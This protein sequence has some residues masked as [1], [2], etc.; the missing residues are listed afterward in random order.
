MPHVRVLPVGKTR[1]ELGEEDPFVSLEETP[2]VLAD[3]RTALPQLRKTLMTRWPL[4]N[5]VEI[6]NRRITRRHNPHD[7]TQVYRD[8][9]FGIAIYISSR[10]VRIFLEEVARGAGK[11]IGP[12]VGRQAVA[13]MRYVQRWVKRMG[14]RVS[15]RNRE[16]T[17]KALPTRKIKKPRRNS[18]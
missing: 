15:S 13:A 14:G 3:V 9:V 12:E 7:P 4:V 1:I 5:A 17:Q 18:R 16:S 2:V 11:K 6:E 10:P 8:A